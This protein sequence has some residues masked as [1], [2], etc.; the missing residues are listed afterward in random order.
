MAIALVGSQSVKGYDAGAGSPI[1]IALPSNPTAGNFIPVV[2]LSG[3]NYAISTVASTNDS[4][5]RAARAKNTT[6]S[7][8]ADIWYAA[9]VVG[10]ANSKSIVIT[11]STSCSAAGWAW[12]FS[13][14]ATSSPLDQ[15][16]GSATSLTPGSLTPGVANE[17]WITGATNAG[18]L[19]ITAPATWTDG[20]VLTWHLT[21]DYGDGAY[22]IE[23]GS[24]AINPTWGGTAS[25]PCSVLASF[26][27]VVVVPSYF[28][29]RPPS[30]VP[31][32]RA[33]S[34]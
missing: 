4:Y 12:E 7:D 24:G 19:T 34:W 25:G 29:Q 32:N 6:S 15:S 27:P 14:V 33:A 2:A 26:K 11:P 22:L 28:A 30:F 3:P 8:T 9:N 23:S 31:L 5:T 18:G 10:G 20:G 13:G 1:T 17:L 21:L 16:G